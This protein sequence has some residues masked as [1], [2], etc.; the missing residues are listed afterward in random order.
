M[1]IPQR[2]PEPGQRARLHQLH[3]RRRGARRDRQLTSAIP[4]RTRAALDFIPEEDRHDPALYPPR[5][6]LERC[7]VSVYKGE[8]IESLYADALTRVLAA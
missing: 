1:C 6:V 5:E 2:R 7:E 3:P 8:E 4:A